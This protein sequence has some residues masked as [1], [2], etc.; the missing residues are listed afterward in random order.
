MKTEDGKTVTISQD[1]GIRGDTTLASLSKLKPAFK[2]GGSTTAGTDLFNNLLSKSK[3]RKLFRAS[4]PY[5]SPFSNKRLTSNNFDL[6]CE[7]QLTSY[8]Q[9][10]NDLHAIH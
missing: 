5:P 1:E 3:L 8:I 10:T 2:E 4:V 7:P 9:F 6:Q